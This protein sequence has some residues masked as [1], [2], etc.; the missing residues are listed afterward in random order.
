MLI[1]ANLSSSCS[2]CT[3]PLENIPHLFFECLDATSFWAHLIFLYKR[4]LSISLDFF[5]P[6][7]WTSTVKQL[8]HSNFDSS[9]PW[10]TLFAFC[11]WT[12]WKT[13]NSNLF[14]NQVLPPSFT[15]AYVEATKFSHITHQITIPTRIPVSLAWKPLLRGTFKLNI[16]GSYLGNIGN[17]GIG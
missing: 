3:H 12:I 8:Q 13:R 11:L 6:T 1:E 15:Q 10:S 2:T 9:L 5:H 16:D 17:G 4:E 14:N 7:N